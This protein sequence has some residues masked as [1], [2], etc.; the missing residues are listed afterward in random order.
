MRDSTV[1]T[2]AR[3]AVAAV[4]AIALAGCASLDADG[5]G[6]ALQPVDLAP[7]AAVL[8]SAQFKQTDG[9][10]ARNEALYVS[11]LRRAPNDAETWF[12][13]GNLYAG[14]HRPEAAA[15]AY[16]RAL[17]ANNADARAL[18]NLGVVRLRQGYA[19]LLQGQMVVSDQDKALAERL[20]QVLQEL[21]RVSVLGA[22]AN[23][24]AEAAAAGQEA[25]P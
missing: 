13:L 18:H 12:R 15:A 7:E 5:A 24:S 11:A 2:L 9:E 17:R 1:R 6:G 4:A 19:A 14:N 23:A 25:T 20:D 3:R 16:A 21:G 22:N 10:V 8:T